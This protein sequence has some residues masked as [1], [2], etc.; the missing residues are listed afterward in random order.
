MPYSKAHYVVAIVLIATIIGFWPSYFGKIGEAP[1]AFHFHGI[2][3]TAWIILLILQAWSI[4][5]RHTILHRTAGRTSLVLFPLL[6]GSLV[7]IANVSAAGYIAGGAYYGLLGPVF[8]YATVPPFIAYLLLYT[9][10]LRHRRQVHLH[11]GYMLG[12][13]FFIWEPAAARLLVKY[14]PPLEISGPA[15]F[16]K[17]IDAIALGIVLPLLLAIFLYFR[18][19]KFGTPFLVVF[20]FLLLQIAGLYLIADTKTWQQIF[21]WYAS[22]PAFITVG[23]GILLGVYATWF[24]WNKPYRSIKGKTFNRS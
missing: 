24:G 14:F 16:Y 5:S 19:R 6:T 3:A 7:M 18:H 9:Q 10:A 8:G 13:A 20:V 22:L 21:A 2:V 1:L 15:D 4:H 17:A 11:A 23:S 12:T